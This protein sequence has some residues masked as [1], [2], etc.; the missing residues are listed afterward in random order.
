MTP[1]RPTA[2]LLDRDGVI[3]AT[4]IDP[5][6]GREESPYVPEDVRLLD[7][8][9]ETVRT[10]RAQAVPIAVVSNQPAVAKQTHTMEELGIVDARVREL[11]AAE[12]AEI[13]VWRYCFHHPDGT[14]PELGIECECRKPRPGLLVDALASL[15][16]APSREVVIAGDSDADIGAGRA[17]GISTILVE[18]P[19]TAHRRGDIAPDRRARSSAVLATMLLSND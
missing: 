4:V 17:I 2:V 19:G 5:R 12:G 3:N 10:L 14:D 8:I 11:L 13:P 6:S 16:V 7:G 15:G 1:C 18:H 9:A